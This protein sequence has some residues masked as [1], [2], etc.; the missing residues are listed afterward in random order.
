[1]IFSRS[2]EEYNEFLAVAY[3]KLST[4]SFITNQIIGLK[5]TVFLSQVSKVVK[6][7]IHVINNQL[8]SLI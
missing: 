2:D 1:M 6:T 3:D 4:S 7:M 8:T 5:K